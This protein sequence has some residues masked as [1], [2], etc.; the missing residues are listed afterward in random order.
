MSKKTYLVY[1]IID[2]SV[3]EEVEADSKEEAIEKAQEVMG[4]PGLCHHCSRQVTIGDF[5]DFEVE[6]AE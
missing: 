6:E 5:V 4:T 2:A 1:G 3:C